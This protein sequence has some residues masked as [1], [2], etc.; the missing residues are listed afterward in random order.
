MHR[1]IDPAAYE[2][3][4]RQE[5]V[6]ECLHTAI[7][8]MD[9]NAIEQFV[10]VI[11]QSYGRDNAFLVRRFEPAPRDE[12]LPIWREPNVGRVH[13]VLQV[14]VRTRYT[15]YRKAFRALRP[16]EAIEHRVLH[17]IMNRRYAA[18]CG[19]EYLRLIPVTREVNSSSAFSEDW[20]VDLEKWVPNYF[21]KHK[22]RGYRVRYAG[23][24]Q[25]VVMMG[26]LPGGGVMETA[27]LAQDLFDVPG[28]R[29]A[30]NSFD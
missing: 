2:T 30:Q 20:G 13:E 22:A 12:R 9:R 15:R 28:L 7:C 14:W 3:A 24:D 1:T 6:P 23:T 11:E 8:A 29:K 19:F 25:I 10:G 16:D 4:M 5:V 17:H 27:R 18:K 26:I 21:E